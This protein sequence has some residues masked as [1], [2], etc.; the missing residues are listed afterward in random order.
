MGGLAKILIESGHHITGSDSSYYPPMSDQL[1][2]LGVKLTEG[3]SVNDLPKADLYVVGNA[4]S[5]GNEA[6]EYILQQNMNYI[7]GPAMLG[8]ILNDK[9]VIAVSG[10]HGK[11]TTTSMICKIFKDAHPEIGY[12]IGGVAGDLDGSARLGSSKFFIIEADEYDSAFFDKRSKFIHY[13]PNTLIIN[14]IEYDHADIFDDLLD[15]LKQFNHLLRVIPPDGDIIFNNNDSA[16]SELM[17]MGIWSNPHIL[18]AMEDYSFNIE[19]KTLQ[20]QRESYD[21][22]ELPIFGSHNLMNAVMAIY[23]ASIHSISV[24]NAFNSLKSYQG[25]KRRLEIVFEDEERTVIDDFAHHPTAI[26][27]TTSALIEQYDSPILGVIELG[28]NTMSSGMHGSD[29]IKSA[30]GLDEVFWL[31][32]KNTLQLENSYK[33]LEELLS[34][35]KEKI[36]QYKLI[37]VMTNKDSKKII[38]PIIDHVDQ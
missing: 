18:G 2:D 31:D 1:K 6:V 37:V 38:N 28:S 22:T 33:D 35:L 34:H 36:S 14:N 26:E 24:K 15:I 23:T 5:R 10:T 25:V 29:L 7:S 3:Y 27:A 12:L 16:T 19:N 13:K 4:L 11:T 8:E 32:T 21:L 17:E 9:H 30:A 20:C